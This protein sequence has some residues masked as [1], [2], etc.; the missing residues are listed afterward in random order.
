MLPKTL[1]LPKAIPIIIPSNEAIKKFKVKYPNV[2]RVNVN[3]L[4]L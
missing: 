2:L 1:Y 4:T 3:K